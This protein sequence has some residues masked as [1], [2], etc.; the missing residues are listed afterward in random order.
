[1]NTQNGLSFGFSVVASGQRS[2]VSEPQL[3][4]SS[5][6]GGFRITS[7]ITLALAL[8]AGDSLMFVS[9]IPQ[10]DTAIKS[11]NPAL[12]DYANNLGLD[13]ESPEA[14]AAIH[15]EFDQWSIAKGFAQFDKKGNAVTRSEVLTKKEKAKFLSEEANFNQALEAAIANA[16]QDTVDALSRDGVTVEEQTDILM[17]FMKGEE[18]QR[19]AGS[20][21]ASTSATTGPGATLTLT[22]SNVWNQLK[23]D[24][25]ADATSFNRVFDIDL[26]QAQEIEVDNGFETVTVKILPLGVFADQKPTRVGVSKDGEESEEEEEVET[27]EEAN[28]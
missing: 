14:H 17:N 11:K 21:L 8:S 13:I 19:Y 25:G 7:A 20:K 5:T 26:S 1:M 18:V 16:P 9:N 15:K 4:A 22:D 24:L 28:D 27:V 2:T 6:S 23:A 12:V 3:I 10:I